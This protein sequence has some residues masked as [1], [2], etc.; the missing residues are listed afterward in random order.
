MRFRHLLRTVA[1]GICRSGIERFAPELLVKRTG[2][3]VRA[4]TGGGGSGDPD[5]HARMETQPPFCCWCGHHARRL[6]GRT[7]TILSQRRRLPSLD[8]PKQRVN[9]SNST[10]VNVQHQNDNLI[11]QY[12]TDGRFLGQKRRWLALHTVIP[13]IC[14]E[15]PVQQK[16]ALSTAVSHRRSWGALLRNWR[17]FVDAGISQRLSTDQFLLCWSPRLRVHGGLPGAT[18]P[19]RADRAAIFRLFRCARPG[20]E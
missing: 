16:Q 12:M 9:L 6:K 20:S 4:E 11:T 5:M 18:R 8:P 15:L 7:W 17:A 3:R 10:A 1:S 2:V 19:G 14:L 13:H